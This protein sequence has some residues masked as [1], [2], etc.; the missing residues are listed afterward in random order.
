MRTGM[1]CVFFV[2]T[3]APV[4]PAKLVHKICEDARTASDPKDKKSRYINRLRPNTL[5][6]KASE[7]GLEQVAKQ[8]LAPWFDL[9]S[10]SGSEARNEEAEVAQGQGEERSAY[11]A[12]ISLISRVSGELG[13]LIL[14]F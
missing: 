1:E 12:S 9:K 10:E 8:V 6:G 7:S 4:E 13:L 3:L 11:S 14:R 5:M 2:K